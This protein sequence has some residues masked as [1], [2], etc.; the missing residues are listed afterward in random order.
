M[1]EQF[2]PKRFE[3][4]VEDILPG[5]APDLDLEHAIEE[6]DDTV[7]EL[8]SDVSG[9]GQKAAKR[10]LLRFEYGFD[11]TDIREHYGITKSTLSKQINQVHRKILNHP[12][13]ARAIGQLRTER[14]GLTRPES[15]DRVLWEGELSLH[16]NPIYTVINYLHGDVTT[17]Y[18][19]QVDLRA[20]FALEDKT[21][22]LR[23]SYLVD[24][25][26]GVLI[27]RILKGLSEEDASGHRYER[28]RT[29]HVYPLPHPEVVGADGSLLD[30]L[31]A[32]VSYDIKRV[33][34]DPAWN[35][36]EKLI[37]IVDTEDSI[38]RPLPEFAL[39]E[40]VIG[41]QTSSTQIRQYT[42]EVHRRNNFEHILRVYPFTRI[43]NIPLQT[44]DLLWDG[45]LAGEDDYL[46]TILRTSDPHYHPGPTR[47]TWSLE[48]TN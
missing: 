31:A 13:L 22:R 25:E 24:E 35:S 45:S 15:E 8:T 47:T 27:K 10:Y 37:N 4:P 38:P 29:C 6:C 2:E 12:I 18:S 14:T 44:L 42:A 28:L 11:T 40:K 26:Y 23:C 43:E 19:W 39:P 30:G 34:E 36:I 20:D 7:E 32:H 9:I 5:G 33:F 21:R 3:K 17:P 1:T 48:L 46:E 16:S 41:E